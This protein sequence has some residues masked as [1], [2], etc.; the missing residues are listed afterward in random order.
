MDSGIPEGVCCE[1]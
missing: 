1:G